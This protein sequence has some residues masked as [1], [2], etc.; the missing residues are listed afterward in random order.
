MV[1]SF[2]VLGFGVSLSLSS[3][4]SYGY[5]PYKALPA[6]AFLFFPALNPIHIDRCLSLGLSQV[7]LRLRSLVVAIL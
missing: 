1:V 4:P 5:P 7:V 6:S 3:P 2:L